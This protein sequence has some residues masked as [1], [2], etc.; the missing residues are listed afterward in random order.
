MSTSKLIRHQEPN[1]GIPAMFLQ[2]YSSRDYC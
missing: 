2:Y 1:P